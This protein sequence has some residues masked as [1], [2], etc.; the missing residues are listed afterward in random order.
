MRFR[1]L[2][3][4]ALVALPMSGMSQLVITKAS[5]RG[6]D[7]V[8]GKEYVVLANHGTSAVN[9][10]N[11]RLRRKSG[12]STINN[13]LTITAGSIPAKSHFLIASSTYGNAAGA[14]EGSTADYVDSNASGLTGG[15]SDSTTGI[16]IALLDNNLNQLDAVSYTGGATAAPTIHKGTAFTGAL[17][18]IGQ[19]SILKRKRAATP[20]PYADTGNNNSDLEISTAKASPENS[21]INNV[22]VSMSAFSID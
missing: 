13:D 3:I 22:P 17:T 2:A 4:A 1:F 9:L 8:A 12:T 21:T 11:Y 18:S 15:L 19:T 14:V 6:S 16:A 7:N 10:T 20:G 5:T